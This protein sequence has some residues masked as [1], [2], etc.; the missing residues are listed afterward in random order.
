M[1][2]RL[3]IFY[4]CIQFSYTNVFSNFKAVMPRNFKLLEELEAGEKGS[5]DG[6][7]SWGLNDDD[8]MTLSVWTCMIIGPP[9]TAFENRMYTLRI[10]TGEDYPIKPPTARFISK[11]KLNCVNENGIVDPNK[12]EVL[13]RWQPTYS[14]RNVLEGLKKQMQHKENHKLS[15]PP[16][17]SQY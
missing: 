10:G 13:K 9:R 12:L 17:N 7:I 15:Q 3:L 16:E 11:I 1:V 2:S 8:D 4:T 5:G 6:T 14:I